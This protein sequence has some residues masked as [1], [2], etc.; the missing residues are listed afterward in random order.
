MPCSAGLRSGKGAAL[1]ARL[2]R[3]C[4]HS[5]PCRVPGSGVAGSAVAGCGVAGCEKNPCAAR[6]PRAWSVIVKLDKV[7]ERYYHSTCQG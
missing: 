7:R 2:R 1:R 5:R 4:L 3:P 6:D